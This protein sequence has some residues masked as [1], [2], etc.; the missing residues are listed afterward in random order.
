MHS[1]V[2]SYQRRGGRL[3]PQLRAALEEDLPRL[4]MP[5]DDPW[6]LNAQFPHASRCVL[7]IG[8]GMGEASLAMAALQP[9]TGL[10]AVEVHDRGVAALTR[11]ATAMQLD[12]IRIHVGDAVAALRDLVEPS[13]LAE[14]RIWFPDPWPKARH[15][16]R[17]LVTPEFIDLVVTRLAPAGRVHVATDHA[18][19][20]EVIASVLAAEARLAPVLLDGPRPEWR[21]LTK[22]ERSGLTAGRRS[23]DYIYVRVDDTT[24]TDPLRR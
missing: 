20:A 18:E 17:R 3:G 8:S 6:D 15:H 13:A 10:I 5:P 14:V 1:R 4:R 21:P 9:E 23:H 2:V 24:A 19:Y 7:E 22:F 11:G 12:N 16:K